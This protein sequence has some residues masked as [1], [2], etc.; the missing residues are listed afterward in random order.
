[1]ES[2]HQAE[3]DLAGTDGSI[4][5]ADILHVVVGHGLPMLFLNTIQSFHSVIPTARLLVIDNG[6]PQSS[7]HR[8][9]VDCCDSNAATEL[10]L[11]EGVGARHAKVGTLYDAYQLAFEIARCQSLSYVHLV[12]GDMQ[13]LWWDD[14]VVRRIGELYARHPRCVNI[15]TKAFPRDRYLMKDVVVDQPSTDY[16][17]PA[18]GMTDIGFFHLRRFDQLGLRFETSEEVTAAKALERGLEVVNSPWPTEVAVPWPA[19]VRRGRQR[20]RE[21][22]SQKPLFCL[23]LDADRIASI[24]A[25]TRPVTLEQLCVPWGWSC[26]SPMFESDLGDWCYLNYRR[27]DL[28]QNGWV[29]G[30]PRWVTSGLDRKLDILFAPHRPSLLALLVQPLPSLMRDLRKR[31]TVPRP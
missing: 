20:G 28:Q 12:Q 26:L 8:D 22:R 11:R 4:R 6:S 1:M 23:P 18:Y 2:D 10:V 7:L 5:E 24:K 17:I 15:S 31:K 21:V 29:H 13:L 19:V 14:D 16:V 27:H 3:P 25:S 9:L 30:S